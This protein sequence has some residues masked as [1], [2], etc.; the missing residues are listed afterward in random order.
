MRCAAD[1]PAFVLSLFDTGLAV[2]R[3]LGKFGVP[4]VGLDFDPSMPG[5]KSKFCRPLICPHPVHHPDRLLELLIAEGKKTKHPG[6]LFPASDAFLLFVSRYRTE[7][8]PFFRFT[9][10]SRDII[11]SIADKHKQYELARQSGILCPQTFFPKNLSDA[12][13]FKGLID[14]PA[15]IK[16]CYSYQWQEKFPKTKGFKVHDHRELVDK[17]RELLPTG[18]R[19]MVQSII[20]GVNT[21]HF[22]VCTYINA[23]G[24]TLA[25]FALRKIRQYPVEFGVGSC[26][27]S[28][29]SE[30]LIRLGMTFFN[31]IAYRGV[32]SIEF[33]KDER[34]GRFKLIELNP[35]YWQQNGLTQACGIDFATIQ[36]L[37]LAGQDP[38]PQRHYRTGIKWLDPMA[39]FQSFLAHRQNGRLSFGSWIRSLRGTRVFSTWAVNDP[40]PFLR[41]IEYGWKLI[42]A[43]L[44]VL[45]K[46]RVKEG[47]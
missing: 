20:P 18:I 28:I 36:Y 27:E 33:K 6:I 39:D 23:A 17:I 31:G 40:G 9:L 8:S 37:D 38:A 43:P 1:F 26:V 24:E 22:K 44:Y 29:H 25:L 19:I 21:N 10:P 13:R 4:V 11:E 45:R 5:F 2:V 46:R 34:D 7:L 47:A 15:I 32:G 3:S 30:E 12:E 41:D 42:K 14:Y 16:A 35:R